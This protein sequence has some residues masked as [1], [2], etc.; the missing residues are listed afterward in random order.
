MSL[1]HSCQRQ[2]I[3]N[4]LG[5]FVI[6]L[7]FSYKVLGQTCKPKDC[8]DLKCFHV[9]SAKEGAFI[10]PSSTS[11]SKLKV[12][13][14][15]TAD[16][17]GG[18]IV[19]M[20]RFD[21]SVSFKQVW[22]KYKSGFGEQSDNKESWLGNENVYQLVKSFEGSHA[23]LR[24]EGYLFN[25]ISCNITSDGFKLESE[26][27]NYKLVFNKTVDYQSIKGVASDWLHHN[28]Q[29]F[30]T[31]DH[32]LG[33]DACFQAHTGGWW[34]AKTGGCYKLYLTGKYM[35]T[36]VSARGMHIKTLGEN[37]T[38]KAC[39]MMFRPTKKIRVCK[40]PCSF[41]G[42]CEYLESTNS[43]RCIC[44]KGYCGFNCETSN[45][46]K[47][48]GSCVLNAAEKKISCVCVGAHTGPYCTDEVEPDTSA[49]LTA[50]GIASVLVVLVIVV[51][52]V[53]T[54]LKNKQRRA[55]EE[56]RLAREE[57]ERQRLLKAIQE[58]EDAKGF[59]DYLF[60]T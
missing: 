4:K 17:V 54:I 19:F 2:R 25:G 51:V 36:N 23:Q 47:N 27:D 56:A 30:A 55:L 20:R 6:V 16:S 57:E 12:T 50:I 34:Y 49:Q 45:P 13:C 3:A 1:M 38:L 11:F 28:N 39:T 37:N 24:V 52:I 8:I 35:P 42:T 46:C 58:K 59:F 14:N 41:G 29:Q 33:N 9:S 48:G 32:T 44:A 5:L 60:P 21:G 22:S 18:W 40:N 10:Y 15:Q 7:L 31:H 26:L 43:H 53:T